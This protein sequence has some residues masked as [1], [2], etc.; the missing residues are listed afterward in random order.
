MFI[1]LNK[2][3]R[4][5]FLKF[6][7]FSK[8]VLDAIVMIGG[9]DMIKT[10]Y[11]IFREWS[12]SGSVYVISDPHFYDH[13]RA[14]MGYEISEE[15]QIEILKKR[16]HK[17]DTLICLGDVGDPSLFSRIRSRKVLIM[18]NHDVSVTKF[19]G[20]FDEVYAGPLWVAEKLV[21]SHEPL[22]LE[23]GMTRKPIA[24]NIH[25]HDHSGEFYND[26]Y[27]LN[28]AQ[29]VFGWEPLDLGRF[30]K[31]GMLSHVKSIHREIIDTATERKK[32]SQR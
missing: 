11:P 4:F 3:R 24:F 9:T 14:F 10:L 26:D 22:C 30:I 8:T 20:F 23:S 13:D 7:Y 29:N 18:G 1:G 17:N 12:K 15:D 6:L 21:L 27:H 28:V 16:C 32:N 5:L 19:E 25:G 2:D 31:D